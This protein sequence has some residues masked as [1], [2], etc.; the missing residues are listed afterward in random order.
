MRSNFKFSIKNYALILVAIIAFS[1]C[2]TQQK[3]LYLQDRVINEEIETIQGGEIR[4]KPNDIISIFVTSKTP[5]LAA[6]FN[7]PRIQ[8]TIGGTSSQSASSGYSG[9]LN[10]TI[11][12]DGNID[13]PV[14]GTLKATGYTK[15][16]L[17]KFIKD[18][19]VLSN[20]IKDPV[21]TVEYAN[22]SFSVMGEVTRPGNY[23]ITD[24]R[25]NILEA[26]SMAGDL[27]INGVRDRVFLTRRL[28]DKQITYQ[29]D[30]KSKDIYQSPA[31]Y[32]QQ[33]DIIYVEPNKVR[34]NQSTVNGN[35][36][37]SASF[38]VSIASFLT[39]ITT[40]FLVR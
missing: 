26:L 5:E 23:S 21:V 8:Q 2:A 1:S 33:K 24:E 4:F 11:D 18:K 6:A 35:T 22:L 15:T 37:R 25:T 29:L 40:L 7:L 20:L 31:Y 28:N 12:P 30:L 36:V 9:T 32:I 14:L 38:W 10:F 27:T 3:V 34:T 13:Y 16:E 19:I 39:S 17:A